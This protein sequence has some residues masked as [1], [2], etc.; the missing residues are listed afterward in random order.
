MGAAPYIATSDPLALVGEVLASP[1]GTHLGQ[2]VSLVRVAT[3]A[4]HSS[5]WNGGV[6]VRGNTAIQKGTA[7]ATFQDGK[8]RNLTNG[9]SHAAVYLT[10]DD[11]GIYVVDQWKGQPG[12]VRLVRFRGGEGAPHNDGDAFSVVA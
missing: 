9:D 2:C 7:I 1:E 5:E 6:K 11:S 8:Y 10:Q 12:H 4:P 3:G